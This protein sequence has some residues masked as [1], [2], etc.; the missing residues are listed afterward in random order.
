MST[1]LTDNQLRG[2]KAALH[3]P[4]V[5]DEAKEH[6]QQILEGDPT[7][8]RAEDLQGEEHQSRQHGGKK[9]TLTSTYV[10][11]PLRTAELL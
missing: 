8:N 4:R 1:E 7:A 10:P 6:A 11:S 5:S 9:A 3:N 2:Y